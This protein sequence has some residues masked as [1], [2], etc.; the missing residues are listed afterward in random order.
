MAWQFKREESKFKELPEG[1]YRVMIDSA[2]MAVSKSSENDMLVIKLSVSGTNTHLWGYITFLDDRPE[3]T[4]RMLTQFFDSFGIDDG[5]FNLVSYVGK[6]GGCQV[7]HD[8]DGRAKVQYFLS[9]KQQEQLP[10]WKGEMPK[11]PTPI[12]DEE[13]LPF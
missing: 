10:P 4:N 12:E 13:E 11:T 2:E 6:V 3:I 1:R 8:A 5:N 9:K 7:K